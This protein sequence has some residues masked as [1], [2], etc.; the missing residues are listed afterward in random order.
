MKK[1]LLTFLMALT[2]SPAFLAADKDYYTEKQVFGLRPKT[3]REMDVGHIGPTGIL[4][5]IYRDVVLKVEGTQPDTPAHGLFKKGDI[6]TGVNGTPHKGKNLFIVLGNAITKAEATDGKLLFDIEREGEKK[7]VMVK[8]P[9]LGTYSNTWPVNCEKSKKIIEHAAEYYSKQFDAGE[10]EDKGV[11]NALVCLFLMS[12]GEDKYLP[13]VRKFYE[14]LIKNPQSI[15]DHTWNNGYNGIAVC[16]YYLRTGDKDV[17]PLIQAYCDNARDR[18]KFGL[19]W[20]HWG[21]GINPGYCGAGIMNPASSQILTTLLLAKECGAD[22]DEKTLLG[23]L[24]FFYRFTGHG[25]VP[26][27]DDRAEGGLGSNGKD[28]M[29]AAAMQ[30]ACGAEGDTTIYQKARDYLSMST[31]TNYPSLIRGHADEGRGDGMWR[32][33]ASIYLVDKQA[34]DYRATIDRIKW[35]YDLSRYANGGMGMATNQR[36]ND[37]GSGAGV[38]M[39]YTAPLKKLRIMGA[40]PSKYTKKFTLPSQLWGNKADLAFLDIE[41]N[42]NYYKYGKNEPTHIPFYIFGSAYHKGSADLKKIDKSEILKNIYHRRY[43]I[44]CEAAKS[45]RKAGY[46]EDLEKLLSDKDP[47]VRRA[48]LDGII[49]YRYWFSMGRE[50]LK[51]EQYTPGMIKAIVKI[52]RDPEEAWY[53]KDGALFAMKNMPADVI[54][55]NLDAI[56]PY[57]K[58]EEWWLRESSFNALSGLDK[59]EE[60]FLKILPTMMEMVINEYHTHPRGNMLWYL[61]RKLN[62]DNLDTPAGKLIIEGLAKAAK[63]SEVKEGFRAAEGAHNVY[64]AVE[65]CLQKDPATAVTMAKTIRDRFKVLNTGQIIKIIGSPNSNRENKPFGLYSLLDKQNKKDKNE[66]T[67]L[68]YSDYRNELLKRLK[69]EG[70]DGIKNQALVNTIIDLKKLKN[71]VAGWQAIGTPSPSERIWHYIDIDPMTEKDVQHKREKKRFRD[72]KLPKNLNN[73]YAVDFDDSK[74]QSGKAPIG[75]GEF[76]Q[77]GVSFEN[78]SFWGYGEFLLMRTTFDLDNLD[79]DSYRISVLASQ[80]FHIYLNGHK[81]HTYVWWKNMPFYRLIPLDETAAKYLRKGKNVLAV[82]SNTEYPHAMKKRDKVLERGQIDCFLEGLR[83]KD[84]GM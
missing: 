71:N 21:K 29:I 42:P 43:M 5:R 77:R 82:Y 55:K 49:D 56:L 7:Q 13:V 54:Q 36:F 61:R 76:K 27:G 17:M 8:I 22:V 51:T 81:I 3:N 35:W 12:T 83:V 15:G 45:L 34:D 47:R 1:A 40:P 32:G 2:F 38:A 73:W 28:S 10:R 33:I 68:L 44:R 31:I 70:K 41:H 11:A 84:L 65:L 72:I 59:D 74:W 23:S 19:G 39:G 75:K 80:G 78:K 9:I 14:P 25:T 37:I 52:L 67:D 4:A 79:Y 66:L 26:Y 30:V 46:L 58:H 57:T 53:V 69:K 20:P 60:L 64:T 63:K 50:P 48:A 18:Q 24:R 6:I 16:E 62:K